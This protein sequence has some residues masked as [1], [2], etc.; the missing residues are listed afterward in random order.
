MGE[1]NIKMPLDECRM[2]MLWKDPAS[3]YLRSD[4]WDVSINGTH[5]TFLLRINGVRVKDG[6]LYLDVVQ[7]DDEKKDELNNTLENDTQQITIELYKTDR[8]VH[9]KFE[10]KVKF[11][12][13]D[14]ELGNNPGVLIYTFRYKIEK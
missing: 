5:N 11:E 7:R 4:L 9:R 2:K 3:E 14:F 8:E 1:D 13:I 6:Y 12:G 10:Y